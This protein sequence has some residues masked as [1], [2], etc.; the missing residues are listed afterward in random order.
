[1]ERSVAAAVGEGVDIACGVAVAVPIGSACW[2]VRLLL[3]YWPTIELFPR[4]RRGRC[5]F[6]QSG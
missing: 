2:V 1:M 4:G 5:I 6:L 3:L